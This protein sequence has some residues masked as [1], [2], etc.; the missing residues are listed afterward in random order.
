[1]NEN[2]SDIRFLY[3]NIKYDRTVEYYPQVT[4]ERKVRQKFHN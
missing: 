3:S 4:K 1:M 2:P